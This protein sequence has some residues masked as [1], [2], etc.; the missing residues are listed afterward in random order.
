MGRHATQTPNR[1]VPSPRARRWLYGVLAAAAPLGVSY[2]LVTGQQAGLWLSL[3][4]AVLGV[5]AIANTP[6][7][8]EDRNDG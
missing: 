8:K 6:S 3:G 7:E 5:V 1:L 4:A 2:D